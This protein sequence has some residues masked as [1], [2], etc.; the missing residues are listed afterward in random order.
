MD[1]SIHFVIW[2]FTSEP[3]SI[4]ASWAHWRIVSTL[5]ALSSDVGSLYSMR[6][7]KPRVFMLVL[8]PEKRAV[9]VEAESAVWESQLYVWNKLIRD[10]NKLQHSRHKDCS[11]ELFQ[12]T[13]AFDQ[14]R[15]VFTFLF[16]FRHQNKLS[17]NFFNFGKLRFPQKSLITLTPGDLN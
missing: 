17:V 5:L 1:L 6:Q 4:P 12:D 14:S 9:A 16:R 8:M 7:S 11:Q 13:K 10:S 15:F 2:F 3:V